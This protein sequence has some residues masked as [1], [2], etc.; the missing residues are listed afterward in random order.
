[1]KSDLNAGLTRLQKSTTGLRERWAETQEHWNDAV[2]REFEEKYLQSILPHVKLAMAAIQQMSEVLD[3][4]HREC[5]D[6]FGQ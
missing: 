2:S 4:A 3:N 1:M 6:R 5:E